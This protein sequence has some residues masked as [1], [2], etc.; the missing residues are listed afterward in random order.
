[1]QCIS[2]ETT[3]LCTSPHEFAGGADGE[4]E[5]K[6]EGRG[7][8]LEEVE[9]QTLARHDEADVK[10]HRLKQDMNCERELLVKKEIFCNSC[11]I[12]AGSLP[13]TVGTP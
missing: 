4:D 6:G 13:E 1:M 11:C 2:S 9:P 5:R 8:Q 7:S 10:V 3:P 12:V